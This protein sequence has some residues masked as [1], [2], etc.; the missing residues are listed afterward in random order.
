MTGGTSFFVYDGGAL[1]AMGDVVFVTLQYRLGVFG[2]LASPVLA[3]ADPSGSTGNT[4]IQ[5]QRAALQWVRDNAAVFGGDPDRVM[6]F[7]ESAG[8]GSVATHLVT[9]RSK[10]LFSAAAMESGPIAP[11]GV[12]PLATATATFNDVVANTPCSNSSELLQCLLVRALCWLTVL[13]D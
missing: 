7:G 5:D 10:G 1:S 9:P 13:I 6:V 4:G 12:V 8:A 3:A 11:W 2:F